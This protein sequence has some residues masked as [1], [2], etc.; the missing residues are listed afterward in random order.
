MQS[1]MTCTDTS[2][3]LRS[4]AAS[5]GRAPSTVSREIYR[6]GGRRRYRASK[7]DQAAQDRAR[8]LRATKQRIGQNRCR[9]SFARVPV[10]SSFLAPL[11]DGFVV[12]QISIKASGYVTRDQ[13]DF[14]IGA[15]NQFL[16][17]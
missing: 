11:I 10:D 4:I 7:A 1:L 13:I 6:N 3:S 12:A 17:T 2:R 14:R 8:R 9:G 16:R 5:L 15:L